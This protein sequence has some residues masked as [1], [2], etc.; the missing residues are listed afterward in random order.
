MY[1]DL[2]GP[3]VISA[4]LHFALLV[5]FMI[6]SMVQPDKKPEELIFELY[7]PPPSGA[8]QPSEPLPTYEPETIEL[9]EI[10]DLPE[11]DVLEP[12]PEDPI[13]PEPE[14]EPKIETVNFQDFVRDNPIEKKPI[15]KPKPPKRIDISKPFEQ[16]EKNLTEIADITLPRTVLSSTTS[17]A[18]QDKLKSYFASLVQAITSSVELHPSRGAPLQTKVLFDLAP[19]GRISNV[20][21]VKGSGDSE[22]DRKV[23][24]GFKRLGGFSPP[25]GWTGTETIPMTI[26]QSD[27]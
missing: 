12:E 14:P 13:E 27:R 24:D 1:F 2:K 8:V 16:L 3:L 10:P 15:P 9:P 6:K 5:F 25:P 21:I 11:E 19:N 18:D 26:I 23:V 7:S 20:R 4:S 22:F 17:S